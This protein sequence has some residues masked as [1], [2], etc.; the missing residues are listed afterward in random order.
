MKTH[1]STGVELTF[2]FNFFFF[3]MRVL[4]GW[5]LGVYV[6]MSEESTATHTSIDLDN[7]R[8]CQM[9]WRVY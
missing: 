7:T 5:L 3:W 9:R 2:F 8:A 1:T 4:F 6:R